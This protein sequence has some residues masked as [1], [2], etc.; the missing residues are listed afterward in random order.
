MA[1][2]ESR[3][4]GKWEEFRHSSGVAWALLGSLPLW[5]VGFFLFRKLF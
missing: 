1:S 5:A 2:P 3:M 4:A